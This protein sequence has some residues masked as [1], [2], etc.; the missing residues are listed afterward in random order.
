MIGWWQCPQYAELLICIQMVMVLILRTIKKDINR[1]WKKF[2]ITIFSFL[3][4]GMQCEDHF[5]LKIKRVSKDE[6]GPGRVAHWLK[7]CPIHQK[8]R[9]F[10]FWWG[11]MCKLYIQVLVRHIW[12]AANPHFSHINLSFFFFKL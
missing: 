5:G 8:V 11:N 12:E 6:L 4:I 10:Y 9:E 1:L 7:R 2:D 3:K